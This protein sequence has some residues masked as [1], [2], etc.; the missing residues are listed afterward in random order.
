MQY[1]KD[2]FYLALRDRL[3]ALNPARTVVVDGVE[4]PAILVAE[5][6]PATAETPLPNAYYLHWGAPQIV[7]GSETAWHPLMK[8]EC[9]VAYTPGSTLAGDVDRGRAGS[10]LDTEVLRLLTP[11]RTVKVDATVTPAV[12]LGTFVFWGTPTFEDLPPSAK[13]GRQG[14]P[15]QRAA[16]VTVFF[17]SEVEQA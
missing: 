10:E 13:S 16:A 14:G 7:A 2:S 9:R 5:N 12:P 3:S 4:R 11:P 8:M 15:P 6:E 1:T 17:F